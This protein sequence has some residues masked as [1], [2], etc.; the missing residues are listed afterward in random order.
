[1]TTL[2]PQTGYILMISYGL[3]MFGL[4]YFY[5]KGSKTNTNFLV[6]DRKVGFMKSGFSTAATWIWAPA[7]FIASQ[8]AYQQGLPGVFWFTFPNILCLCIFAY[9]AHYLRKKFK[10]GFTLAQYMNVRHS[11]RVQILYIISLSALSICQFAVQLLAGGAVVTYLTGID[12]TI[13]TII[14]TA[15]AL[16]YSFVSG[17]RAS[18][19]T[20]VWQM[21]I[22]LVVVLVVVPLV[23][24]K[25]G[26]HEV[27]VK[28]IGG[29]SGEFT[30]VFD[31]GVAWSFGVVVTI[32]LL[33]GPFGDQ[34]FWQRAFTTKQNEVKKSFLL[35]ALV[36][37]VVPIFTSI[38]G[39][40]GA[41]LGIDAGNKA[42]L[43]NI[44]TVSELLPKAI[45]IPF[46]WMLLSGLVSTLDSGLCAISSI[47]STDLDMKA[48]N[49]LTRA[50]SGMVLL[51]IGGIII[52]NIPD[53][54]ILYL[55]IFYGTLRAST[56][57]PTIYTIINKK[58]SETG[59]FYGICT[60]LGFGV[61]VFAFAK[62]NGLTDLAV[63]SS[64]FVV[65]ASG[66][67]IYYFTNY[68][69]IKKTR[70]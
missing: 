49:K 16:S 24:V 68:G 18:I 41:G 70:N 51:A 59:M 23:Y 58:V 13:V 25:G 1:M 50:R 55:F 46:V 30:N 56:L 42:Q 52:A 22:I 38:I 26:G 48:K 61:P 19:M 44:I 66:V 34:S 65:T 6:A 27:L 31:P 40:M 39:F 35:S 37:G 63:W 47:A 3:F 69:S 20:D 67:M 36:F 21:I 7:L 57:L 28:G 17:I 43:I 5:L 62:F 64:I 45:L 10:N 2:T 4:S 12:F 15:I 33:A 14:L 29:I 9:F 60:S 32:G 8:K 54:K 53:M 11:R